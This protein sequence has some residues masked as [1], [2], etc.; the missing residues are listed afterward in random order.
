VT[1]DGADPTPSVLPRA[2]H[3]AYLAN[4]LTVLG[5]LYAAW[6]LHNRRRAASKGNVVGGPGT[7]WAA[8]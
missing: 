4:L 8:A 3:L 6:A 7:T 2:E 5:I 1:G